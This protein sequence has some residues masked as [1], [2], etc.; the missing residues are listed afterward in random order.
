MLFLLSLLGVFASFSVHAATLPS[1]TC[2]VS[3]LVPALPGNAGQGN[4]EMTECLVTN[5]LIK[6]YSH[7]RCKSASCFDHLGCWLPIIQLHKQQLDVSISIQIRSTRLTSTAQTVPKPHYTISTALPNLHSLSMNLS[8][9]LKHLSTDHQSYSSRPP[10][11]SLAI[12]HLLL[13]R[14]ILDRHQM[15]RLV[16]RLPLTCADQRADV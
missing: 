15:R 8:L 1:H 7:A 3:H 4:R 14:I 6:L 12:L 10:Q 16:F 5:L 2:D 11:R 9:P 13:A